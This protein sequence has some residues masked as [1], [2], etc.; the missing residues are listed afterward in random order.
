M[1]NKITIIFFV[2]VA[3]I[4]LEE[5]NR[6]TVTGGNMFFSKFENKVLKEYQ[7]SLK[8]DNSI[9]NIIKVFTE[10]YS[11]VNKDFNRD[12]NADML[13]FQYGVYDWGDGENLEIDFVPSY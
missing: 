8:S 9:T 11:I 4:I 3:L 10:N 6:T 2:F 12:E 7:E 5:V 13:L 1:K